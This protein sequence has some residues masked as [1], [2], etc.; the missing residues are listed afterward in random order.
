[1]NHN[2]QAMFSYYHRQYGASTEA[3][4]KAMIT[5]DDKVAL[6]NPFID[7]SKFEALYPSAKKEV[8]LGAHIVSLAKDEKPQRIDGL[9]SHYFLDR[10]SSL[11]PALLPL[12]AGARVLDMC[13]A[14][15]GKLLCL[16][17]RNIDDAFFV[18]NDISSLR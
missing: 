18:A 3:L 1:M 15:G 16:L 14:P 10:S 17:S 7:A 5:H 6:I 2:F 11:S 9:L 4:L 12:K 13:S 8:M